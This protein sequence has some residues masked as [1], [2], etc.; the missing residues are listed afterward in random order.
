MIDLAAVLDEAHGPFMDTA[1]VMMNLDLVIAP[2]TAITHLAGALGV[3]VWLAMSAAGDWRW[4]RDRDDSPWYPTIRLFRQRTLNDWAD[5]FSRMREARGAASTPPSAFRGARRRVGRTIS[6]AARTAAAS[7][8][9][10][11]V[12]PF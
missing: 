6:F 10:A 2:D 1:A 11:Q 7:D 5:V 3:P 9:A 12:R 4:L 8:G